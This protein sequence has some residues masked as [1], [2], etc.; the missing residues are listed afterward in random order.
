MKQPYTEIK[1]I[2]K[3]I[4]LKTMTTIHKITEVMLLPPR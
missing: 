3:V 1:P 4:P 2:F